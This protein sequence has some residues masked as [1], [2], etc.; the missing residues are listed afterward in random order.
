MSINPSITL[1]IFVGAFKSH[2][3]I[4]HGTDQL[5]AGCAEGLFQYMSGAG[6]TTISI[7]TGTLGAGKGTGVGIFIS[8]PTLSA[9]LLASFE[10]HLVK[11]SYSPIVA[12]AIA[13][14]ITSSL[15]QAAINTVN[16]G[17]GVGIGKIQ[18]IPNGGGVAIFG[19]ALLGAGVAGSMAP[20][21]A[22]AIALAL[23]SVITSAQGAVAIA[24]PPSNLSGSG[25]SIGTVT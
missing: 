9:A 18:C 5:A 12:E 8:L 25:A 10:G 3:L 23:D 19:A 16:T 24:G 14:G 21:L 2:S 13:T 4:G 22:T 1:P 20:S 11:G 6:C 7:D 17:V 15:A